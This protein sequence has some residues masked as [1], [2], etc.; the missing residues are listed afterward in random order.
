MSETSAEYSKGNLVL[1]RNKP[2]IVTTP[3]DKIEIKLATGKTV[4]VRP[5][6]IELLHIGPATDFTRLP[7]PDAAEINEVLALLEGET[8]TLTEVMELLYGQDSP[9]AALAVYELIK[10]GLYFTGTISCLQANSPD[11][12]AKERSRRKDKIADQEAWTAFIERVRHKNILESD[13]DKLQ[14]LENVAYGKNGISRIL[15][16]LGTESTPENAH[17]LLLDLGYWDFRNNPYIKKFGFSTNVAYPEVPGAIPDE[18]RLDL[19]HLP[20]FA[21]DDEGNTD[22]DDAISCDNGKLW[23]HVADVA[24][25]VHPD[26]ALDRC[27]RSQ[28]AT[29][30]LPEK[31]VTM[32]PQKVTELFG[33]GLSAT[34]P[35]L[36]FGL[37]FND[38]GEI[39]TFEIHPT[40]IHVTRISYAQAETMLEQSP[41]KEIY[42]R[43]LKYN[44]YRKANG[45]VQLNFPEVKIRVQDDAVQ[46]T[47]LPD[48]RSQELV[49]NA[50]LMAGEAAALFAAKHDIPF[51]F[52]TQPA[53][54]YT[55]IPE[56]LHTPKT[57]AEM[58]AFRKY[59]KPGQIKSTTEPHAGLGLAA[60]SRVTSPIR[61]YVDLIAHQ[62]LRAFLRNRPLMDEQQMVNRVG[63]FE[64][65]IGN[66]NKLERSSNRHW[67]LVYL[68]QHPEW[69]G[70]GIIVEKR[71]RFSIVVIPELALESRIVVS[72]N[73]TPDSEITLSVKGIDLV[74]QE[75]YFTVEKR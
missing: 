23:I 3:G 72:E 75:V 47:R 46:I 19:T 43:C 56:A 29:L 52:T 9:A 2:T 33:L 44:D 12:I 10:D 25:I 5:K 41:L 15:K 71:E 34:S 42:D 17:Q 63:A 37:T 35:A 58:F 39:D 53:P 30:Y 64:A 27:A 1:Y 4:S 8:T 49:S 40:V 11:G 32:L 21:I 48:L 59:L 50:M 38:T 70:K 61:R 31:T 66:V 67:T 69:I 26:S 57:L 73:I 62:Q 13:H 74:R 16:E 20:A 24:A 28:A 7:P 45:A 51:L 14:D 60:Y 36:S 65:I 6:D 18:E 68:M 55:D 22:P 54:D